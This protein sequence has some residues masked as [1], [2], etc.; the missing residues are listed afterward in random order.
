MTLADF[1]PDHVAVHEM[2]HGLEYQIPGA[3][4]RAR[5]FRAY[6]VK[7]EQ[8]T[9]MLAKFG[10]QYT[11]DEEGYED[12]FGKFFG[13]GSSSAFYTGKAYKHG[14]TEIISMGVQSL[15]NNPVDFAEKDPEY[16]KFIIGI[17]RGDLR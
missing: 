8:P 5:E 12:E 10:G 4:E 6:R 1:D 2:G 14:S 11:A 17:L 15:Y 9:N 3:Q 7:G 13:A 16:A